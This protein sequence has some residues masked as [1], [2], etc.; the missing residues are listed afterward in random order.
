MINKIPTRE[1]ALEL[2]KKY[3]KSDS[4][5]RHAL[6]VEGTMKHFA[7]IFNEPD[8]EKWTIVGLIH[9][10]D[11]EMYPE[12]HCIKVQEILKEEG[13]P[14]D[15]IRAVAS[16]GFGICCDIQPVEKMEKVLYAID[17][18]T[19]LITAVALLR[20][21]RSVLD[22]EPKSVKKKWK[23][24]AFASGVDRSV[25]EKGIEMLGMERDDV[26]RE[27]ILAMRKVAEE[28]GLKGEL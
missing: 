16:H 10:L 24:K 7:E 8:V 23:D 27:T 25:I 9:D 21:S 1:E 13:Y 18:L 14:E 20:P 15:Y 11:Y 4:L 3:N 22:L 12:E 5:L 19:G 28:I 26:I 6:A 17:E 2:F